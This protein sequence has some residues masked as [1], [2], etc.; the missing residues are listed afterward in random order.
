M[1][2]VHHIR[3]GRSHPDY[4]TFPCQTDVITSTF[5]RSRV[6]LPIPCLTSTL[7]P[8]ESCHPFSYLP[9][10]RTVIRTFHQLSHSLTAEHAVCQRSSRAQPVTDDHCSEIIRTNWVQIRKSQLCISIT[11][12]TA[13]ITSDFLLFL[14][15]SLDLIQ[16][17]P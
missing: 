12:R 17:A 7:P 16:C 10:G 2:Q 1:S 13:D 14:C 15:Y 8:A 4:P 3:L 6:R 11:L 5:R 9:L